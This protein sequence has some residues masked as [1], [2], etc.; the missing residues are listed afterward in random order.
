MSHDHPIDLTPTILALTP[1]SIAVWHNFTRAGM[2]VGI[3]VAL[4]LLF[5]L[6]VFVII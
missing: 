4:L 3:A 1:N 2:Y 6:V 5:M